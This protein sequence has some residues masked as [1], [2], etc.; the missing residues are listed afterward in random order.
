M[1]FSDPISFLGHVLI[2]QEQ[3][4]ENKAVKNLQRE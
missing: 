1:S 3:E 4:K 2:K